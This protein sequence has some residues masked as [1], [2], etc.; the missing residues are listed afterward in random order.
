MK[1]TIAVILGL[2]IFLS[3]DPP[4][5]YNY[6]IINNCNEVI[7]VKIEAC[8]LNCGETYAHKYEILNIHINPN[9]TQLVLSD[10]YFQPLSENMVEYFFED[11]TITKGNKTSKVNY[12]NKD[13]WE[14]KKTKKNHADSYL[15]V[16]PED[17]E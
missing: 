16:Y 1:K 14:F 12:V 13:L 6:Y 10:S 11:I 4:R 3:C 9:S 15:T 5:Y 2:I 17:F 8:S 7:D